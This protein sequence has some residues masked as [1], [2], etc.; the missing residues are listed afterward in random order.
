MFEGIGPLAKTAGKAGAKHPKT[1]RGKLVGKNERRRKVRASDKLL[2][3][4]S[5]VLLR[6][7]HLHPA[8]SAPVAIQAPRVG[9]L[10]A[11]TGFETMD[12]PAILHPTGATAP[13]V[14]EWLSADEPPE[15]D[16]MCKTHSSSCSARQGGRS[17]SEGLQHVSTS[18]R[19]SKVALL[20]CQAD[21]DRAARRRVH[22]CSPRDVGCKPVAFSC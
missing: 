2:D 5:S 17:G 21:L 19:G 11:R 18:G 3:S 15:N 7:L 12:H 8:S 16:A 14:L 10:G 20:P 6:F 4:I 1:E 22:A 9:T 13:V